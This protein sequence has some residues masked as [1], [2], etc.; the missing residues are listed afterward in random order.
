MASA[1]CARQCVSSW[2]VFANWPLARANSR[3]RLGFTT[4][5]ARPAWA[6]SATTA[7][8]KPPLASSTINVG[9]TALMRLRKSSNAAGALGVDHCSPVGR[10]ATSSCDFDTSIPT[11][12]SD[13]WRMVASLWR[14]ITRASEI[15]TQASLQLFGLTGV[16]QHAI[17]ALRRVRN[18]M[19]NDLSC[20]S[21]IVPDNHPNQLGHGEHTLRRLS[22]PMT[23]GLPCPLVSY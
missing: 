17:Y 2:F 4:A 11:K 7:A 13:A 23:I 16:F 1:K 12:I 6:S 9:A 8:S 19:T 20:C 22:G 15:R 18:P 5:T 10:T 3:M 21:I 14:H